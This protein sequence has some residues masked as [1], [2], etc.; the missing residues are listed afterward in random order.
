MCLHVRILEMLQPLQNK[1]NV[2]I[3]RNEWIFLPF[4][5][6]PVFCIFQ[7]IAPVS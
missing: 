2:D 7:V 3:K 5:P 6:L 1:N 4:L